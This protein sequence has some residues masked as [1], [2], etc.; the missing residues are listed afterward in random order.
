MA[1]KI[2]S[3]YNAGKAKY[4]QVPRT[5]DY[6]KPKSSGG[7]VCY[8]CTSMVSC[9]YLYAGLN[10]MYDKSCSGGSLVAEI[11]KNG[12]EMWL[13]NDSGLSKA[14]PGDVLLK[15][16]SSVSQSQMGKQISTS[17]AMVYIG[18]GQIAHA[19][20]PSSGIKIEDLK[21][22][23][24]WKDGKHFF[25]RPKDLI[26]ADKQAENN[27]GI[28]AGNTT[29]K[30]IGDDKL[31][32]ASLMRYTNTNNQSFKREAETIGEIDGLS[33]V[34]KIPKAVCSSYYGGNNS[35]SGLGLE[36][37]KTCASHNIPYGTKLYIPS[38]KEQLGGD[39]I[40]IVTD[41]GNPTFD[42][43]IYMKTNIKKMNADVYVISWGDGN[44]APSYTW[45]MNLYSDNQWSNLKYLWNN[46]KL[47]NGKLMNFL[48]FNQEDTNIKNHKRF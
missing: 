4:C 11:V 30:E 34:A 47:M 2:V 28:T 44:I 40:V 8:D 31:T 24:R 12:G 20:S 26:E 43:N 23:F 14:K 39:G 36:N 17:H 7:K 9:C 15:A 25:V 29:T 22:S 46:Y 33:Y 21:S 38:L 3:D 18:G 35:A 19:S 48:L 13:L 42:F 16:N 41:T 10:S 5:I 27:S 1:K 45:A 37:N 32:T 6:T